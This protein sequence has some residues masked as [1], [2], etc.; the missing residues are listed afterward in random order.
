MNPIGGYFEIELNQNREYHTSAL[1]LNTGRN[2]L[3]YILRAKSFKK[4]YLPYYTCDV[5]LEPI[6]NLGLNYEFYQIDKTFFPIFNFSKVKSDEVLIYNNY[7]GICSQQVSEVTKKCQNV[8]IDNSQAFYSKPLSGVDTFYSPRKFFGIPDGAYL[9]TDKMLEIELEHD[10][11]Y[12]RCEHLLGRLD[13]GAE[14]FYK[15]FKKNDDALIGQPIKR[16]SNLT[17]RM[18]KSFKY[19]SIAKKRVENFNSL[20]DELQKMN[21]LK[22]ELTDDDVPMVYPYLIDNG[23]EQKKKLIENKIFTATYWPNVKNWVADGSQFEIHLCNNLIALP[24]DQ[25]YSTE[26]MIKILELI[27]NQ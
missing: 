2:A 5:M 18:L 23:S 17:K 4:V 7:F 27:K 22:I 19:K 20:H 14:N 15:S 16:M 8:I 10:I 9:Y 24:I 25:R 12:K 6:I 21:Q 3:E 13:I 11:S 26:E 1:R